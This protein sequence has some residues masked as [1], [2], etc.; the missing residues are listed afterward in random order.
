MSG[1]ISYTTV[2]YFVID[3]FILIGLFRTVAAPLRVSIRVKL[4]PLSP[5]RDAHRAGGTARFRIFPRAA[6]N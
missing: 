3:I 2:Y 4:L 5:P 1:C 6:S